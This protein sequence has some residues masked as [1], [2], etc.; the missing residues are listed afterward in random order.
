M[1]QQQR[2]LGD[3]IFLFYKLFNN[4]KLVFNKFILFPRSFSF[5]K[6]SHIFTFFLYFSFWTLSNP[7]LISRTC[8]PVVVN[9]EIWHHNWQLMAFCLTQ[10]HGAESAILSLKL[11]SG[12]SKTKQS[13]AGM[14]SF[15]LKVPLCNLHP[16]I[17]DFVPCDQVV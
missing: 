3:N 4:L 1:M 10:S 2:V 12:T 5:S 14:S 11:H 13:Q 16:S 9:Y 15:V 6:I 7:I 8:W 17:T